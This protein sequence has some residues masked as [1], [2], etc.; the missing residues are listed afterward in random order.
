MF[1]KIF[2]QDKLGYN[3][4]KDNHFQFDNKLEDQNT[5]KTYLNYG[6]KYYC[7][8]YVYLIIMI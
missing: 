4:Q 1:S 2:K 6:F 3:K 7:T 8:R 5:L